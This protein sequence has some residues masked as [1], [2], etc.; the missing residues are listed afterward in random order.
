MRDRLQDVPFPASAQIGVVAFSHTFID[1]GSESGRRCKFPQQSQGARRKQAF[2]K[3][4]KGEVSPV[5]MDDCCDR[6]QDGY[7]GAGDN[8]IRQ[9][10]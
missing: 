2:L 1:H 4:N 10:R 6:Y 7:G 3:P 8:G 9:D 5:T